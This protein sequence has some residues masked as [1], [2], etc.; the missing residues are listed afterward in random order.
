MYIVVRQSK[1]NKKVTVKPTQS[2]ALARG[3][4]DRH[5]PHLL[6]GMMALTIVDVA[7]QPEAVAPG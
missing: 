6:R 4:N 7:L 2:L 1:R 5:N 3:D